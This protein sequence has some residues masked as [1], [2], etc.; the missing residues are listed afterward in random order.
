[1]P[2]SGTIREMVGGTRVPGDAESVRN[3][4]RRFVHQNFSRSRDN[5]STSQGRVLPGL[6]SAS[7]G[8]ALELVWWEPS[9]DVEHEGIL[10][11][12]TDY[13]AWSK[14]VAERRDSGQ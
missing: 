8:G 10:A 13:L 5:L 1:M 11:G 3:F 7:T 2:G 14:S 6:L 4:V 12:T 9:C